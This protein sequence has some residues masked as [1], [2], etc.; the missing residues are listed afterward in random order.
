MNGR[1][2]YFNTVNFRLKIAKWSH[3][4]VVKGRTFFAGG[5]WNAGSIPAWH[6]PVLSSS[7]YL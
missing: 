6:L 7:F 1:E 2:R 5:S 3:G 4:P